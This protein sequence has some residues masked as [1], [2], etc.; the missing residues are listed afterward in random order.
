MSGK[1]AAA[2]GNIFRSMTASWRPYV[3]L[4]LVVAGLYA[5]TLRFDFSGH[6]DYQ[7]IKEKAGMLTNLANVLKAFETDVVWGHQEMYYRP[8]LTLSFMADAIWGGMKPFAFHLGNLLLHLLA[9]LLLFRF[10]SRLG[11]PPGRGLVASLFFAVHPLLAQGVGWI[12]GRND[13]LLTVL[14]LGSFLAFIEYL[15]K[16]SN[17]VLDAHLV[18]FLLALLSKETAVFLPVMAFVYWLLSRKNDKNDGGVNIILP[19]AG[20][21]M[22]AAVYYLLRMNAIKPGAGVAAARVNTLSQNLTGFV[23][24][25]GKVFFPFK[26]SGDPI[27]ADLPVGYGLFSLAGL[28]AV[29]ILGGIRDRKLFWFG[30]SWFILFLVPTFLGNTS[31]ANFAEHRMYLPLCGFAVM[32]LQSGLKLSSRPERTAAAAVV[33]IW[34][35]AFVLLN[36]LHTR[37]YANRFSYWGNTVKNSPHSYHAHNMLGRCYAQ[38]GSYARAEEEFIIS[39]KMNPQHTTAYNDLGLLYLGQGRA[40]E[41]EAVFRELLAR[42]PSNAGARNNLGLL[43][44]Q[45]NR[46]DEAEREFLESAKLNPGKAEIYDNLGVVHFKRGSL[47]QAEQY[48]LQAAALD[49]EDIKVN[50]HLAS[51]YYR[52][53]EYPKAIDHYDKAIS[54]G[55]TPDARVEEA[56]RP[57]RR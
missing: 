21:I 53:R 30:L 46:L 39:W 45:Q 32:L 36:V 34:L 54:L 37:N 2:A 29:F 49:P 35:L 25:I 38:E 5:Q 14:V 1:N 11:I 47:P 31:Y 19:I 22:M 18:L 13:P 16:G 27:P 33:T 43:Y 12:P 56:L 4:A 15:Q 42:E 40:G 24:Y 41:A 6:D 44:L 10:L 3:L 51:L 55:M 52:A 48:F 57:H 28:A 7:L 9:V 20:W 23:S 50:F 8:V 26:L 17:W